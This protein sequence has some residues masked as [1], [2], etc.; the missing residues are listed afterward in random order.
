MRVG[1]LIFLP[2][3][4]S[5]T[6]VG[7]ETDIDYY[8]VLHVK[9]SVKLSTIRRAY[10]K[11]ALRLHPDTSGCDTT[12]Q[13]QILGEAKHILTSEMDRN[14]YN[15]L[16]PKA[17]FWTEPYDWGMDDCERK[18][19]SIT[20]KYHLKT[21]QWL[22]VLQKWVTNFLW[23]QIPSLRSYIDLYYN[24]LTDYVVIGVLLVSSATLWSRDLVG[25][26][27]SA[28]S[29]IFYGLHLLTIAYS[30]RHLFMTEIVKNL[31]VHLM[32]GPSLKSTLSENNFILNC[33]IYMMLST[34]VVA[35]LFYK[36]H[37]FYVTRVRDS[38][39]TVVTVVGCVC[40]LVSLN[41]EIQLDLNT[42][43]TDVSVFSLVVC[44]LV[45]YILR[46]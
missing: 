3:L 22:K 31:L 6:F 10:R 4:V 8:Q 41:T 1:F 32:K 20:Q 27:I 17:G 16:H 13:F 28:I 37:T 45:L 40:V 2:V 5:T 46:S 12:K 7:L 24:I 29:S 42:S 43:S 36:Y 15:M 9:R 19:M 34:A 30:S 18:N 33:Y 44:G 25:Q 23:M 38:V 26:Y 11:L 21:K 35:L 39:W 14:L